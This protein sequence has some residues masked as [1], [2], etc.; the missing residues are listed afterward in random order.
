[1]TC[2]RRPL[3][4]HEIQGAIST[5]TKDRTIDFTQRFRIHIREI[6]GSLI[7]ELSGERLEL[8]HSTAKQYVVFTKSSVLLGIIQALIVS[9]LSHSERVC[10]A[11]IYRI[12]S[13]LVVPELSHV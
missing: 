3:K 1:M 8:V 11:E 2:A 9:Q 4:W 5:N 6:C 12:L 13:W 7:N 10:S